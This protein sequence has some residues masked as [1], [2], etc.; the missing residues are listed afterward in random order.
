MKEVSGEANEFLSP[1]SDIVVV[2]LGHSVA[3]PFAGQILADSGA[4]VIKIE[5]ASGDDARGWGPPFI[6]GSATVFQ[7]L[8]RNKQSVVCNFRDPEQLKELKSLILDKADVVVQNLRP[9]QVDKLGLDGATLR[10]AKPS[11]IYCNMGAFGHT[12]PLKDL[13]GYD[14][15]M[16]AF[17]G[18]MSTTGE[19]GRPSVRVGASIVDMGT[20]MWASMAIMSALYSRQ[21]SGQGSI[22]DVSLYE[23]AATW[24]SLI[25]SQAM[26]DGEAP[27]RHG[28]GAASIVPYK[29]YTTSDGEI[30]V[31]AGSD[32][33]FEKLANELGH[34]EW[35]ADP[36]FSDNRNRV[37]NQKELYG[38]L[39]K[40][41]ATTNTAEWMSRMQQAGIPCSPVNDVIQMLA[42]PQTT[43]LG[44]I[45]AVPGSSLSVIGQPISVNGVRSA[46]RTAPPA[47]GE[48][49]EQIM[50]K[51]RS[52]KPLP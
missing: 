35:I 16:Q 2:E 21:R 27:D 45:Q 17:S 8:N 4:T 24:M 41:F 3:A 10:S 12:G 44:L 36:L 47:L 25:A 37:I 15:L 11:L 29:A 5:K 7:A 38:R 49:T 46:P 14:P 40:I 31:A 30:V 52:E 51:Y 50:N 43:A 20:G 13:P 48:H 42:H 39:D 34:A 33:L 6:D 23:T 26:V 18:I 19:Q 32:G 9:G 28:S 1:Y 22:I